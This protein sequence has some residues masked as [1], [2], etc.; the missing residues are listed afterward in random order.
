MGPTC[1]ALAVAGMMACAGDSAPAGPERAPKTAPAPADRAD[2]P[3]AAEVDD[4]ASIAIFARPSEDPRVGPQTELWV[5]I[6]VPPSRVEL[7]VVP[8]M[9]QVDLTDPSLAEVS[10]WWI[11][12]PV[13]FR[14]E[15]HDGAV[16][17][18]RRTGDGP[19]EPTGLSVPLPAGR[20]ARYVVGQ[21]QLV[22]RKTRPPRP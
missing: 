17:V 8:G 3:A 14:L 13:E 18:S 1:R 6:G 19:F 7:G 11:S 12:G 20:V 5:E 15:Q 22:E 10:C 9:C 21:P 2:Q 16:R 4:A